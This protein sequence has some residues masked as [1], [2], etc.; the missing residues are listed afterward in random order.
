[1]SRF[2]VENVRD[3]PEGDL[4]R[5]ELLVLVMSGA[6]RSSNERRVV[7]YESRRSVR[8]RGGLVMREV[9]LKSLMRLR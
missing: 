8:V 9:E 5:N 2:E 1:M 3:Y 4:V 6:L 7:N